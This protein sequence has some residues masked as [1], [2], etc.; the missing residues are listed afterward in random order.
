MSTTLFGSRPRDLQANKASRMLV[1]RRLDALGHAPGV[2]DGIFNARTRAAIR[3]FQQSQ[4]LEVTGYLNANT[5]RQLIVAS[6][7]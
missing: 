7:R 3:R 6:V 1:E 2:V 5:V 4:R